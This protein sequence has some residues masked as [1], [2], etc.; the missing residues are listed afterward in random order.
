MEDVISCSIQITR[1]ED[2]A[3]ILQSEEFKSHSYSNFKT[4]RNQ[5]HNYFNR[6]PVQRAQN[7]NESIIIID[8]DSD[9]STNNTEASALRDRLVSNGERAQQRR[10]FNNGSHSSFLSQSIK[11]QKELEEIVKSD[12]ILARKLQADLD[13]EQ[14]EI[15]SRSRMERLQISN[16]DRANNRRLPTT[17]TSSY[18][19]ASREH[20]ENLSEAYRQ[21]LNSSSP[22]FSYRRSSP[23]INRPIPPSIEQ[24]MFN[25]VARNISSNEL[26][27]RDTQF[28]T[29]SINNDINRPINTNP[30]TSTSTNDINRRINSNSVVTNDLNR[31]L[32]SNSTSNDHFNSIINPLG[33]EPSTS[34]RLNSR[35]Y[36]RRMAPLS[37]SHFNNHRQMI[38]NTSAMIRSRNSGNRTPFDLNSLL[39]NDR[40]NDSYEALLRLE[41]RNVKKRVTRE[42][43]C[44]LSSFQ[45][46][47]IQN[48]VSESDRTCS[49]CFDD[50]TDKCKLTS[51]IC[52]HKFHSTCIKKW[53]NQSR[54]CPL[55]Q[56]DAITGT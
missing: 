38:N 33:A 19:S 18:P 30:T 27:N 24:D 50:Y 22:V 8:S 4:S 43:I 3:R 56:K 28:S 23:R 51:L 46:K 44:S 16:Q 1:D 37:T 2:Y 12:E 9:D 45:F 26:S 35:N 48:N 7:N 55:C 6:S 40:D 25:L 54:R 17:T 39:Y 49:I 36:Q 15:L 20:T 32:N 29:D 47:K 31:L 34:S 52:S 41:E 14:A 13:K 42:E 11:R 53:L 5:N 21:I 10:Q